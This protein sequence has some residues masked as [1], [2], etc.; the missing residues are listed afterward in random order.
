MFRVLVP[1]GRIGISDIVAED[2]LSPTERAE[3]GSYVGCVAGALSRTEYLDGLAAAGFVDADVSFT[4]EAAPGMYGAII[5]AT[6]PA[7]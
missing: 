7:G 4:H 5:R 2:H 1:G 6:K 3:R